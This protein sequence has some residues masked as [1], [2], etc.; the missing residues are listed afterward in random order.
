VAPSVEVSDA[1]LLERF[2]RFRD[3]VAIETLLWRH[4]PMVLTTCRRLLDHH[5]DSEDCFQ[6]T[7]LVL[8]RRAGRITKRRSVGSWLYKV[9]YRICL[10]LRAARLRQPVCSPEV[11]ER[12]AAETVPDIERRELRSLLDAELNRLPER[13][14]APLVLHYLEVA[15]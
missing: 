10:R 5:A 1:E 13:Y 12:A 8:C 11:P 7:F 15:L 3:E 14:R 4:G 2:V 9:A 6:A